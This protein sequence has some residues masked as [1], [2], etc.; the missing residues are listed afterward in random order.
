MWLCLL[1]WFR[2]IYNH[3]S[4][5]IDT[6]PRLQVI[7]A[8]RCLASAVARA[9]RNLG[10]KLA[11]HPKTRPTPP[12]TSPEYPYNKTLDPALFCQVP[13]VSEVTSWRL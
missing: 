1:R 5:H 9:P 7:L 13:Y 11:L 3:N 10:C 2:Y 4:Y 12:Y 8:C 6:S